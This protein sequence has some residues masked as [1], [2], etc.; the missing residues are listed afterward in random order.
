MELSIYDIIKKI[1]VTPKSVLLRKKFGKITFEVHKSANKVMVRNAVE[2]IWNVKVGDVRV[3]NRAGKQKMVARK[4][5]ILPSSK[6]AIIT[7]KPGYSIDLPDQ[8]E[9]MGA[10]Q[11]Q[12][13][14]K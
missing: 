9:S 3:I 1:V 10:S 4:T 7:L 14:G 8:I 5:F 2:K 11:T 13:V 12:A 6:K